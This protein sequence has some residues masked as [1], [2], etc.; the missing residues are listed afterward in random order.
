MT[1]GIRKLIVLGLVGGVFLLGN[2]LVLAHW[3]NEMGVIESAGRFRSEF[4]TGTAITIIVSLL[5]LLVPAR[6]IVGDAASLIR[7]CPICDHALS[8]NGRYCS[9]CG[10]RV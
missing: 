9:E 3:L 7:R 5:V 8:R 6:Q 1:L 2:A 4:L 10:G